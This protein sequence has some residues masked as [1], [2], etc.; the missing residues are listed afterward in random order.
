AA[1]ARDQ[2]SGRIENA[3]P[4]AQ[5]AD[6]HSDIGFAHGLLPGV[7]SAGDFSVSCLA[8]KRSAEREPRGPAAHPS[9][10]LNSRRFDPS[11]DDRQ[12]RKMDRVRTGSTA[13]KIHNQPAPENAGTKHLERPP[14]GGL[15]IYFGEHSPL[16]A[17][18]E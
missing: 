9:Q 8:G 14:T 5:R 17:A 6:V 4:G 10:R 3:G 11:P 15:S 16:F 12:V 2:P 18:V 13:A 1:G 7:K